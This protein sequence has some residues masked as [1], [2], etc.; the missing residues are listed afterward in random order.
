M[1]A[2]HRQVIVFTHDTVFLGELREQIERQQVASLVR[3]LEWANGIPG[4]VNEGLP[5]EHRGYNERLDTL[6]QNQKRIEKSWQVYPNAEQREKMRH[7]YDAMRATIERAIQDIVFNDVIKPYRDYIQVG[8][9]DE[10]GG[11]SNS[12]CKEIKRLYNH[13]GDIINA[14]DPSSAKNATVPTPTE[15]GNDIAALEAV[16]QTIKDARKSTAGAKTPST[17]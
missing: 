4:Y 13:C 9:L 6:K 1:E 14:H 15:L 7:Q 5:W 2:A 3:H 17:P 12:Q 11:L 10:V 16:I 8:K